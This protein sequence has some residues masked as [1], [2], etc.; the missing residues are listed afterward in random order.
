MQNEGAGTTDA[1][2]GVVSRVLLCGCDDGCRQAF[3]WS[4]PS[5]EVQAMPVVEKALAPRDLEALCIQVVI[6]GQ[7][8]AC[9]GGVSKAFVPFR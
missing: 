5:Q 8:F 1:I 2:A 6:L 4:A 9:S 3:G 7:Q